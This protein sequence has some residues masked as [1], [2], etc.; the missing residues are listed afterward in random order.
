MAWSKMR[1]RTAGLPNFIADDALAMAEQLIAWQ[2][3]AAQHSIVGQ[4]AYADA[5]A[6]AFGGLDLRAL[7]QLPPP[8]IAQHI[9]ALV[10]QVGLFVL[11][12]DAGALDMLDQESRWTADLPAVHVARFDQANTP[13]YTPTRRQQLINR[14]AFQSLVHRAAALTYAERLPSVPVHSQTHGQALHRTVVALFDAVIDEA[15]QQ[16]DGTARSLRRV[17]AIALQLINERSGDEPEDGLMQFS[18]NMPSLVCAHLAYREARQAG[19]I[20]GANPVAHPSFMP[21]TLVIPPWP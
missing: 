5:Y 12:D 8:E 16:N 15:N 3:K 11:A 10:R 21:T 19:R 2:L 7:L 13:I 20:R 14:T 9:A 17:Q 1:F 6:S 18:A 4:Q